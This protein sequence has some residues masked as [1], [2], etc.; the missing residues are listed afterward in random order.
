MRLFRYP[1]QII[2]KTHLPDGRECTMNVRI[3]GVGNLVAAIHKALTRRKDKGVPFLGCEIKAI[4][5]T[6]HEFIYI[7][8]PDTHELDLYDEK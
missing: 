4:S 2:A 5:P 1:F 8:N 3:E 7:Y 6:N